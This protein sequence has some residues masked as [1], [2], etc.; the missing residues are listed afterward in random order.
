MV[1]SYHG[2]LSPYKYLEPLV[3]LEAEPNSTKL[4]NQ[5]VPR[6]L[7]H[8]ISMIEVIPNSETQVQIRTL[9][10]RKTLQGCGA[11]HLH[12]AHQKS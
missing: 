6:H 5:R 10:D 4:L 3:S 12:A 8:I 7:Q 11:A 2:N 1:G 9:T